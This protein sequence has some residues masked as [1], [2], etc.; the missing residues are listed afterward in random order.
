MA[1][2]IIS[3]KLSLPLHDKLKF[4]DIDYICKVIIE[5]YSNK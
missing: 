2:S 5:F 4:S 1:K 3:K